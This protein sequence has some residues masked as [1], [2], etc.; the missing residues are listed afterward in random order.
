MNAGGALRVTV[1]T[2]GAAQFRDFT[3]TGPP[4]IV[5][6]LPGLRSSSGSKTIP[7]VTGLVDRVRV[8]EPGP[9]AVRIV[10]DVRVMT[11]YRV[12]RDGETLTIIVGDESVAAGPPAR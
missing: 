7:V 1:R 2:N 3:L 11:R 5:I 9:G 4:R 12:L 6:D 8:G 10:I